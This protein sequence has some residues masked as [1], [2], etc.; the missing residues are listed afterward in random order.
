MHGG[1]N[2]GAPKGN[3]NAFK[4]GPEYT[5]VAF[6]IAQK[7]GVSSRDIPPE[8]V[9]AKLANL[10]VKRALREAKR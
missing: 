6:M 9:W 4:H 1:T 8:L 7:Y 3:Q 2:P 5:Q 10:K